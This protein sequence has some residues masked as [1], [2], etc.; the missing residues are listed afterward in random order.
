MMN[1]KGSFVNASGDYSTGA[2]QIILPHVVGTLEVYEQQTVWPVVVD[3]TELMV[4]WG[5][6]PV[7]TNQIS[8]VIAR[9]RRLRRA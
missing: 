7:L 4:F 1:L 2:A 3:N 6:D 8:W 9:P 5:A